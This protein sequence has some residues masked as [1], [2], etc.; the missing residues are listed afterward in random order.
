MGSKKFFFSGQKK[1][2]FVGHGSLKLWSNDHKN[3]GG[4]MPA[5]L[6]IFFQKNYILAI[7]IIHFL[8]FKI[9]KTDLEKK[10]MC[11]MLYLNLGPIAC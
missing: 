6:I 1:F 7:W 9:F 3:L 8:I 4:I 2:F 10:S 5:F 11:C